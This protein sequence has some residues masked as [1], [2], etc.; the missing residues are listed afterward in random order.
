MKRALHNGVLANKGKIMSTIFKKIIDKEIPAK[1]VYEDELC[2]AFYDVSPQAP[3]HILMIPK[4]EIR[5]MAETT[6]EDKALL[7]HMMF[8]CA[9]IARKLGVDQKGYR[10]VVNTNSWGGQSVF[11]LH[12]HLLSGR[13]MQWPPG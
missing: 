1:V 4:K 10:L 11:H 13:A 12:I 5:S 7:G 8:Q 6:S 3:T 9:E 2:M